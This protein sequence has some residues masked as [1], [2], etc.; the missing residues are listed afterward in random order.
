M[1]TTAHQRKC[2]RTHV[3]MRDGADVS[4]RTRAPAHCYTCAVTLTVS[5]CNAKG[6]VGK[7]SMTLALASA[8]AASGLQVLVIDMDPQAT[9]TECLGYPDTGDHPTAYDVMATRTAGCAAGAILT[10]SWDHVDVLPADD[11]LVAHD[12]GDTPVD[13][14]RTGLQGAVDDYDLVL[15]DCPPSVARLTLNAL[16]AS[17]LALVVTEPSK[18]GSRGV[19]KIIDAVQQ[20]CTAA[21]PDL[22]LAGIVV[23]LMPPTGREATLRLEELK[24]DLGPDVWPYHVPRRA[25]VAESLGADRPLSDYGLEA[26]AVTIPVAS[27]LTRLLAEGS[28]TARR[29][30]A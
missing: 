29:V 13:A 30:K 19:L 4:V 3:H 23:N 9:A 8:A 7:T 16:T 24:T 20:V 28:R 27:I 17:T 15:I 26:A 18:P 12:G 25:L 10:S 14:L 11:S 2:C 6:G 5:M 21:N 1:R 22:R